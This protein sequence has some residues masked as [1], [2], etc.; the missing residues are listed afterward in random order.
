MQPWKV[1]GRE[2]QHQVSKEEMRSTGKG[3]KEED[4]E[5]EEDLGDGSEE[6]CGGDIEVKV[7]DLRWRI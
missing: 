3:L 5:E 6:G 7:E 1:T 4:L 2:W